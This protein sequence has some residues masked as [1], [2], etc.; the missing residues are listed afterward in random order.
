MENEKVAIG[1]TLYQP[2]KRMSGS[3]DKYEVVSIGRKWISLDRGARCTIDGLM[4][5]CGGYTPQR[6]YTSIEAY[7][8]NRKLSAAWAD[9]QRDLDRAR[10]PDG[11]TVEAI[12]AIRA[13]LGLQV[14]ENPQ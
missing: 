13:Q 10:R 2:V 8:A 9:L 1:Q 5:D 14:L 6:L 4:L 7:E 12:N 11:L 3:Y